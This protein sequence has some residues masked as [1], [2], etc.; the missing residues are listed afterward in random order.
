MDGGFLGRPNPYGQI[1]VEGWQSRGLP[2]STDNGDGVSYESIR[3]EVL[4]EGQG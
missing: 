2:T 4:G 3:D 1:E